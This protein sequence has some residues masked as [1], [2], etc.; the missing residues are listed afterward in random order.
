VR[1]ADDP[2]LPYVS[3]V[4]LSWVDSTG[5][6]AHWLEGT[7]VFVDVA[8]FTALSERLGR[9]GRAGTEELTDLLNGAFA[10]LLTAA[11]EDGGS[12]LSFGGDALLLFFHGPEHQRR[13]AHAGAVIRRKPAEIG[14]LQT[15]VGSVRLRLSMG[16]HSGRFLFLVT[17]EDAR[18]VLLLGADVTTTVRLEQRA[19][20]GQ[21]LLGPALAAAVPEAAGPLLEGAAL[22]RRLPRPARSD[23]PHRA[24]PVVEDPSRFLAPALREHIAGHPPAEHRRVAV[25][26]VQL[27]GTDALLAQDPDRAVQAVDEVVVT[28]Q[29]AAAEYGVC[30]LGSDVDADGAKLILVGGAPIATEHEEE[31][32]LRACRAVLDLDSPLVLRGGV[33]AGHVFVGDVGPPYRRA[34]TVMGER[35][36]LAA[37]LMGSAG[38][39]ELRT[40]PKVLAASSTRFAVT[41]LDPL[42]LK[43]IREPVEAISV[44]TPLGQVHVRASRGLV[45]RDEELNALRAALRRGGGSVEV[46]GPPGSGK[47]ALLDALLDET[48]LPTL[49][50]AA[51]PYETG[52]PF[53]LVKRILRELLGVDAEAPALDVGRRAA[54]VLPAL[55]AQ[56]LA[57][58]LVAAHAEL[59]GDGPAAGPVLHDDLFLQRLTR[60]TTRALHLLVPGRALLVV[61]DVQWADPSSA[62]LLAAAARRLTDAPWLL[63]T[64][65]R[66]ELPPAGAVWLGP[67]SPQAATALV[68]ARTESAPL[69]PHRVATLVARGGGNPL[70]LTELV[71]SSS[72]AEELPDSVEAVVNARLDAMPGYLRTLLRTASVLGARF[73]L[74]LLRELGGFVPDKH[75]WREL[76]GL[77]RRQGSAAAFSSEVLRDVAYGSLP[78]RTRRELHRQ[79]GRLLAARGSDDVE[80]LALHAALAHDDALTW[81]YAVEAG[82]RAS[83][84]G[85]H[86]QAISAFRRAVSAHQRGALGDPAELGP[87]HALLGDA[88][89]RA[90]R[91]ADALAPYRRA[92]QLS[93]RPDDPALLRR[94][95]KARLELGRLAA[96]RR[97][98]TRGL[99]AVTPDDEPVHLELLELSV[100]V[101]LRQGRYA[102]AIRSCELLIARTDH[103][104]HLRTNAHARDLLHL[105]LTTIG[106]PRRVEHRT[107]ALAVFE[108]LG[109]VNGQAHVLNNLGLDAYYEGRWTEASELFERSRVCEEAD[110]NDVGAAIS[111]MN[112]AEVLLDQGSFEQAHLR[113]LRARRTFLADDYLVGIAYVDSYLGRLETRRGR[114]DDAERHLDDA[115]RALREMGSS[116]L[117]PDLLV[118]E[119]E[120]AT[121]RG[122][123]DDARRLL[124]ELDAMPDVG[125]EMRPWSLRLRAALA[126]RDGDDRSAEALLR[127]AVSLQDGTGRFASALARHSLAVLLARRDDPESATQQHA[128]LEALRRLGVHQLRDPLAGDDMVVIGVARDLAPLSAGE[129]DAAAAV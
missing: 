80:L 88:L 90:G 84:R 110:A 123:P 72:E 6:A 30:L 64:S 51:A 19:V 78:Y 22:L 87:V 81:Q 67:L 2:C 23:G 8:G 91:P 32:L 117:Q 122:R 35:V 44:G 53:G 85:A 96:A 60:A 38:P 34:F 54:E 75:E 101:Q 82:R 47:T 28:A 42:R 98:L 129:R 46:A 119:A 116:S 7:L 99:R 112:T 76:D 10:R 39:G 57:L 29:R 120:L 50:V 111:D 3:R 37:R 86:E 124:A 12:L 18:V 25:G 107:Q 45:G 59:D 105:A 61:E 100:S 48:D 73:D 65:R 1:V 118:R 95:A 13:A 41:A 115:R 121:F 114:Y 17:G 58:L 113:L 49:R 79:V 31:R 77:L 71:R 56:D 127:Q 97:W 106:D 109:D 5:P 52:S 94:E 126:A 21:L 89:V 66:A 83:A 9:Q 43:G 74:A 11:Y 92:R 68:H 24:D 14:S 26:F 104:E 33:T 55:T 93:A 70:F 125:S 20:A 62:A 108:Q 69:S 63:V 40:T 102:G 16:A 103:T 15:S 4:P 27:R 36:N 128:A